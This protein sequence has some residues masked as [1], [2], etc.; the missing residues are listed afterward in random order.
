M[1]RKPRLTDEELSRVMTAHVL[2]ELV[3]GGD[4][5]AEGYPCC[6]IQAA[7]VTNAVF[8]ESN[9]LRDHA[10]NWFDTCYQKYWTDVEFL[11]RL[12]ERGLS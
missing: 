9:D 10:F 12:R 8:D 6:L 5:T 3:R 1:S 2:G 4:Y 7:K 11:A